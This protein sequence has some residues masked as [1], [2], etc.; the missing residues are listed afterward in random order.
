MPNTY[1]E[2][3][4]THFGSCSYRGSSQARNRTRAL[5]PDRTHEEVLLFEKT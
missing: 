2:A 4:V 3:D 1:L 5:N